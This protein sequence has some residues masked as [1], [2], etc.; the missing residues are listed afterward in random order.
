MPEPQKSRAQQLIGDF[1]LKLASLRDDVLFGDMRVAIAA[2]SPSLPLI[3]NGSTE[4][5]RSH[6]KLARENGL[7]ETELKGTIIH[8]ALYAVWRRAMSAITIAKEVFA[9]D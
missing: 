8:L 1:I 4:Q 5:L 7:T 2:S 9:A 3:T 6:L